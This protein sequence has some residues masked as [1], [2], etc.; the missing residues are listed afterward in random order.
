MRFGAEASGCA[1]GLAT[2]ALS[3]FTLICGACGWM[4]W[5]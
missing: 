5:W 1:A 3:D 4:G 2:E